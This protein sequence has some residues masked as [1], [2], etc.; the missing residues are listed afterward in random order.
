MTVVLQTAV[1]RKSANNRSQ[2]PLAIGLAVFSA[3]AVLIPIDGC[4]INPTRSFGP[5]LVNA[6]RYAPE[7]SPFK[8]MWIFWVGPL[9]G[10]GLAAGHYKVLEK[11]S[12][13]GTETSE[14]A[15]KAETT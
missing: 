15:S 2:A 7:Q 1:N 13:E 4:S 10:A 6:I 11:L 12:P 3:H 5:A 8:D 14:D 9:L